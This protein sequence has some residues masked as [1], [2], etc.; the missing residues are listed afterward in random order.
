MTGIVTSNKMTNALVVTVYR[1]KIHPKYQK[2]YKVR[3]KYSVACSDSSKF[4][5]GQEVTIKEC[6]PISKTISF[7][8]EE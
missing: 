2:R 1:T 7:R 8:V 3:K 5:I 4:K 6:R